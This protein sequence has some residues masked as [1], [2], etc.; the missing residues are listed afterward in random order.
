MLSCSFNSKE[1]KMFSSLLLVVEKKP[2][3][4]HV[5]TVQKLEPGWHVL[6]FQCSWTST[7]QWPPAYLAKHP[8]KWMQ[9]FML[10][11]LTWKEMPLALFVKER[12]AATKWVTTPWAI[13]TRG[14]TYGLVHK[15]Y[16]IEINQNFQVLRIYNTGHS[17][18]IGCWK[19]FYLAFCS[20]A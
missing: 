6:A 14:I 7:H 11:W 18:L 15:W 17:W 19:L 12:C 8:Y 1:T 20:F 4:S 5:C 9:C 16:P 10:T 13:M 2:D 3:N